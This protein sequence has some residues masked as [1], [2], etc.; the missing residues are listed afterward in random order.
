MLQCVAEC[1]FQYVAVRCSETTDEFD[2]PPALAGCVCVCVCDRES[3]RTSEMREKA[4]QCVCVHR[5]PYM[6]WLRLAG[7]FKLHVSFAEYRLFYRAL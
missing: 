3:A 6:G 5:I 4:R 2:T 7:S 1:L